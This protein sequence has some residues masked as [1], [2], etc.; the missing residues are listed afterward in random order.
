MM[1]HSD[2]KSK[3]HADLN[4]RL[5]NHP[6]LKNDDAS[7]NDKTDTDAQ[8]GSIK[9]SGKKPISTRKISAMIIGAA[10]LIVILATIYRIVAGKDIG[11]NEITAIALLVMLF[12]SAITWG[13]KHDQDG[14]FIHD[15][16]GQKITEKSSKISYHIL[17]FVILASVAAVHWVHGTV[18]VFLL[19]V[20]FPGSTISAAF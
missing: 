16:L 3:E 2:K 11:F 19:V 1:T 12:F 9:T 7:N 5:N 10:A 4:E 6:P 20:P 15:E 13:N 17:L 8:D 18:N 14:I